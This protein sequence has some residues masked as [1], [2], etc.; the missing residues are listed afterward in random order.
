MAV[1]GAAPFLMAQASVG[2]TTP[3]DLVVPSLDAAT[4]GHTQVTLDWSAVN[5]ATG[6]NVYYD[7]A[8]KAQ[9]IA[10]ARNTLSYVD[11][12]L[13]NG[14]EYCYKVT[15]YDATCESGFSNILCAT[16]TAQGQTTDPVGVSTLE[17]GVYIGRGKDKTFTPQTTFTA[18]DGVVIRTVVLDGVTGLSVADATVDLLITGPESVTLVTAPS[19]A[20]GIAET[21][22]NTQAPRKNNPGTTPG[23]YTVEVKGVTAAGYHWDAVT[24]STG[25]TIQ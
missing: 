18:G 12:A 24:T 2:G 9:L 1:D 11:A 16:P 7:Q 14:V 15:A 23:D 19:D 10:D 5:G 13:T 22:W 21:T 6:Y 8:G 3:C 17:T 25:F 4:P 20:T